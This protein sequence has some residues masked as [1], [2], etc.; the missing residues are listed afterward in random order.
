MKRERLRERSRSTTTPLVDRSD[1]PAP[2]RKKT[3]ADPLAPRN[4]RI[5]RRFSRHL[6]TSSLLSQWTFNIRPWRRRH[7]AEPDGTPSFIT[8]A[9]SVANFRSKLFIIDANV[10]FNYKLRSEVI[11]R[12]S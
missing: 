8:T 6:S 1:H 9:T 12:T 3:I 4:R 10:S 2:R 7:N 11:L 5:S